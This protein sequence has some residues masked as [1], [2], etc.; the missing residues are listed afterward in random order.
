MER[1]CVYCASS[2]QADGMYGDAA[3]RLGEILAR[4]SLTVVYGGASIGSMGALA[5]GAIEAGGNV[6]GVIPKFMD[7][8]EVTHDGLTDLHVVDDMHTRKRRMLELADAVVALPGGSGTL[9]ELLEAITWKRL[10]LFLNPI[11]L[12]NIGGFFDNLAMLLDRSIEERFMVQ[13][14][15][16]MWEMVDEVDE[17]LPAI[18][19]SST[20]SASAGRFASP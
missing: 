3:R 9:E 10:G 18:E 19:A 8:V 13:E 7:R 15:R 2:R 17:V 11:I 16:A 1:V 12:V 5:N 4:Q 6:I 14:H 20:W